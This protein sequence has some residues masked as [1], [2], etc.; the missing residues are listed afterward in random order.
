[1]DATTINQNIASLS[2][3]SEK[4]LKLEYDVTTYVSLPSKSKS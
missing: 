1:M 4:E 2:K 3:S